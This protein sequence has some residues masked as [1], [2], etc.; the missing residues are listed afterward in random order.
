MR[1][2]CPICESEPSDSF[3]MDFVVPSGWPLPETN[4]IKLCPACGFIWHDN[5]NTQADYD[6]FYRSFYGYGTDTDYDKKRMMEMATQISARYKTDAKIIDIGGNSGYLEKCLRELGFNNVRTLN[7]GEEYDDGYDVAIFTHVLEHIH[8]LDEFMAGVKGCLNDNGVVIV[9]VPDSYLFT[10]CG[11]PHMLDYHQKH[12][13]HFSMH[14]LNALFAKH[15]FAIW[16]IEHYMFKLTNSPCIRATYLKGGIDGIFD[17]IKRRI[18]NFTDET[19]R[20]ITQKIK[21][22]VIIYG[23]GDL[24]WHILASTTNPQI[25]I[26]GLVDND[27]AYKG[28]TVNG[29]LVKDKVEG[30][31]PILVMASGQK[32][33]I[34]DKIRA[35]GLTNEVIDL[36]EL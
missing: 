21:E 8:N 16:E 35:D 4:I 36:D 10:A 3:Q 7:V 13:N 33:N 25:P 30:D 31:Y 26:A 32:Q 19:A 18:M 11:W 28:C 23:L 12:I 15:G 17:N 9:D 20:K 29:V 14:S 6:K 27:P 1:E 5:D 22:P 2:N 24:A 34:I